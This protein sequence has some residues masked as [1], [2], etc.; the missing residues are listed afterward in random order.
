MYVFS[1]K[2]YANCFEDTESRRF[3]VKY[4]WPAVVNGHVFIDTRDDLWAPHPKDTCMI[5]GLKIEKSWCLPSK[6]ITGIFSECKIGVIIKT[7]WQFKQLTSILDEDIA[8]ATG[9][10]LISFTPLSIE[11]Y[12][13]G[14][15][16]DDPPVVYGIKGFSKGVSACT[17]RESNAK[18]NGYQIMDYIGF[19]DYCYDRWHEKQMQDLKENCAKKLAANYTYGKTAVKTFVDEFEKKTGP[20]DPSMKLKSDDPVVVSMSL[21]D[22]VFEKIRKSIDQNIID[23]VMRDPYDIHISS[24]GFDT[25]ARFYRNGKLVKE[26]KAELHPDDKFN[27]HTGAELAFDRLFEKKPKEKKTPKFKPG[28]KIRVKRDLRTGVLYGNI[29]INHLMAD[30][31]GDVVTVASIEP[32][33]YATSGIIIRIEEDQSQWCWTP[34]MFELV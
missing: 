11:H 4:G 27:F 14:S 30:I 31:R 3:N 5:P 24:N 19:I 25:T 2:M 17:H 20:W 10:K 7:D 6:F 13:I 15:R 12:F 16:Y 26:T 32:Y 29:A 9:E 33:A 34:E 23:R 8:W 1:K 18:Y 28:D 22:G 21:T